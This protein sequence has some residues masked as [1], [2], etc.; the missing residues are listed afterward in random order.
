MAVNVQPDVRRRTDEFE[1]EYVAVQTAPTATPPDNAAD[2][3]TGDINAGATLLTLLERSAQTLRHTAESVEHRGLKLLL[4]VMAQERA[5]MLNQLRQALGR[6]EVNPL[7]PARKPISRSLKQGLQ[8]IETSMTVQRLGRESVTLN[9]LLSEED[10]LLAAYSALASGSNRTPLGELL[11]T[12]RMQIAKFDQRL[13]AVGDGIEPIVA[14]VFDSRSDGE[15]AVKELQEGGLLASQIDAAPISYVARPV[16]RATVIPASPVH[17]MAAGAAS[18]AMIGALVGAALA[19]FVWLTPAVVGWLTVGPWALFLGAALIGA[20]FGTVFGYFIGQS[21]R[22][23]DLMV[24][25]D[26]LVNGE[27]LVVAYPHPDQVTQAEEILQ[28]YHARELN[29]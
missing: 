23:D 6:T 20:V 27:F 3:A 19:A 11:E 18:G 24:T 4:K 8:E 15:R 22:E 14:R 2:V 26:G 21:R 5:N 1:R 25:A 29:R 7:D 16:M 10:S 12:Q 28:L 17:T 13:K 9:H